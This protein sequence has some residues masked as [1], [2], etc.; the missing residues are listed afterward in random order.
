MVPHKEWMLY[1]PNREFSFARVEGPTMPVP[2]V[3]PEGV[4]MLEAYFSWNFVTAALVKEPKSVVSF[5][6]DP[7]PET[8]IRVAESWFSK[9]CKHFTSVPE[10]PA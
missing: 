5:P 9:D 6:G 7:T 3:N 10:A 4:R 2:A 8:A 1:L